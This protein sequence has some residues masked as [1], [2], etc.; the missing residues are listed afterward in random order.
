MLYTI[1][2]STLGILTIFWLYG[3]I[4][5]HGND[6]PNCIFGYAITPRTLFLL[7]VIFF[8]F[9][10]LYKFVRM[11]LRWIKHVFID[12]ICEML[13]MGFLNIIWMMIRGLF[14]LVFKI[15]D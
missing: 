3:L 13:V 6:I 9:I 14:M 2:I 7:G 5:Y 1:L 4:F 12:I 10:Q 8:P 11:L 15:F